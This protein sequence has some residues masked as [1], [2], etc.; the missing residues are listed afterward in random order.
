MAEIKHV[1]PS[2]AV[3]PYRDLFS[4]VTI[5]PPGKSLA[6]ISTQWAGDADSNVVHPDDVQGQSKVIWT[7][8]AGI[9]KEL[10]AGMKDVVHTTVTFRYALSLYHMSFLWKG[11]SV[12][13]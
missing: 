10:G 11:W 6:Y 3:P 9:L 12:W 7:N 8:I 2:S 5:V 4:S 1:N 13:S